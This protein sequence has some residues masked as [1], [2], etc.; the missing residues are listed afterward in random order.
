MRRAKLA[1]TVD[2]MLK[3]AVIGNGR[4]ADLVEVRLD[5]LWVREVEIDDS[6]DEAETKRRARKEIEYEALPL[7]SVD[8]RCCAI[9]IQTR[10]RTPCNIDMQA[11]KTRRL[12]SGR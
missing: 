9:F 12:L 4:G 5:N 1:Y 8:S 7:E 3:D 10:D 2:E 6:E 11:R